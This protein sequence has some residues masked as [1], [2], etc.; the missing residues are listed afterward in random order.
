MFSSFYSVLFSKSLVLE[1]LLV[2]SMDTLRLEHVVNT[3]L[4][5]LTGESVGSVGKAGKSVV[6]GPVA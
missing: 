5:D 6:R 3:R 2:L 4:S 1:I